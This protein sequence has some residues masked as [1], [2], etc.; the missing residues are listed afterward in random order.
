[1]GYIQEQNYTAMYQLIDVEAS[2]QVSEEDFV[3]CNSAI[4]EGWKYKIWLLQ[5]FPVTWKHPPGI[6]DCPE[7]TDME[8]ERRRAYASDW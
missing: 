6:P 5:L 8:K 4:Y 3:K 1:M 2:G 7:K